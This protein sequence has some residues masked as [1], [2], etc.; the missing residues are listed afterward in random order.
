MQLAHHRSE[1]DYM[2]FVHDKDMLFT[3][4]QEQAEE[5]LRLRSNFNALL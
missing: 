3:K 2:R 4:Y 5:L 1:E